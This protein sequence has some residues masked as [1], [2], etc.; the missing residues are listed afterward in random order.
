MKFYDETKVSI[1]ISLILPHISLAFSFLMMVAETG[2]LKDI[3]ER[4]FVK[5]SG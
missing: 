2:M 3:M 1:R 4:T 5:C